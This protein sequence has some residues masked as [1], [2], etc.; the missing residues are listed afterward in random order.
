[1]KIKQMVEY[2]QNDTLKDEWKLVVIGLCIILSG[3]F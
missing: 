2:R 3:V 1:M